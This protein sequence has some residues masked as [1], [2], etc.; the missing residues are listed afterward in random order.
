LVDLLQ[1]VVYPQRFGMITCNP[2]F[3]PVPSTEDGGLEGPAKTIPTKYGCFSNGGASGDS[4]LAEVLSLANRMLNDGGFAAI[5]SEFFFE[6]D[7]NTESFDAN[8]LLK[9][10][11]SYWTRSHESS[12]GN[13]LACRA[14]LL[15]NEYPISATSYAAR[16]ADSEEEVIAWNRHLERVN[17]AACSPGFLYLQK[18]VVASTQSDNVWIHLAVPKSSHGSIWTPGNTFGVQCTQSAARKFFG[19]KSLRNPSSTEDDTRRRTR[20]TRLHADL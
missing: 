13:A 3:L 2:P 6:E 16:R 19:M 18:Y 20:Q 15:T 17:I 10:L 12:L 7:H 9:R 11:C 1:H 8:F 14:I 4:V 5:V